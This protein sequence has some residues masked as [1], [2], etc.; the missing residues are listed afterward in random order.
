VP[1]TLDV[2]SSPSNSLV[3]VSQ[4]RRFTRIGGVPGILHQQ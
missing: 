4:R 3:C 1:S 2:T